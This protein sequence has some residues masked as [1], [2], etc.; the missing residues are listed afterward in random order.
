MISFVRGPLFQ[1][2]SGVVSGVPIQTSGN[3]TLGLA[4]TLPDI[5]GGI[6]R[7]TRTPTFEV[8]MQAPHLTAIMQAYSSNDIMELEHMSCGDSCSTVIKVGFGPAN[9]AYLIWFPCRVLGLGQIAPS[10][11]PKLWKSR[12]LIRAPTSQFQ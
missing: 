1:R 10:R 5:Y 2:A 3:M 4:T 12:A 9:E 8:A 7:D 11:I 6:S